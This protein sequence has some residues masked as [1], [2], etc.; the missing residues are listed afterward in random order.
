M[1]RK[2]VV[3]YRDPFTIVEVSETVTMG[4]ETFTVKGIGAAKR[5]LIDAPARAI[6]KK[7]ARGRA[8]KDFSAKLEN[9]KRAYKVEEVAG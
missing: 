7:A 4:N 1:S 6:G 3:H 5:D 9:A 8:M 2:V